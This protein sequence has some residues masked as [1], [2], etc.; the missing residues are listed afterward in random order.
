MDKPQRRTPSAFAVAFVL[1]APILALGLGAPPASAAT[2]VL[3][4]FQGGERTVNVTFGYA[5]WNDTLAIGIPY[6]SHV[7]SA[8]VTVSGLQGPSIVHGVMDFSGGAVGSDRW[9]MSEGGSAIYPPKAD[10]YGAAWTAIESWDVTNISKEDG[11]YWHT[12]TPDLTGPPPWERSI[13]VYQFRPS[14]A[15]STTFE[16]TWNG[17]G[18][19]NNNESFRYQ[20][21]LW[22]YDHEDLGWA[23]KAS[24]SSNTMGDVW[25][26]ASLEAGGRYQ[27]TNGSI[28]VAVVSPYSNV[29][30]KPPR[31][32]YDHG[33]L[34]TDYIALEVGEAGPLE[35]PSMVNLTVGAMTARLSAGEMTGSVVVGDADGLA[36]AIQAIIDAAPVKGGNLSV[37]FNL[38]VARATL[39]GVEVASLRIEHDPP[40][41]QPPAYTGPDLFEVAEDSGW[42]D[43]LTFD[44]HFTDD[45]NQ[46]QLVYSVVSVSD[47][48]SLAAMVSPQPN[49]TRTLSVRPDADF[50]GDVE[51]VIGA[52]DLFDVVGISGPLTVR[53]TQVPDAPRIEP[54]LDLTATEG[55]PFDYT[56]DCSDADLPAD[57]LTFSDDT[58]LF[59]IDPGT[60]RIN[61]TPAADQ[62]GPHS[63]VVTLTDSFG[64]SD[65]LTVRITVLNVNDGPRIT[66]PLSI[67]ATQGV[68]VVY[69]IEVADP[70]L[71][72][73][74]ALVYGAYSATV[75]VTVDQAMGT[76]TFTP[77]NDNVPSIDIILTVRDRD[78][79]TDQRTLRVRVANV[80]DPPTLVDPGTQRVDQGETVSVRLVLGDV[81][82]SLPLPVPERLT[83][84]GDGPA[85][86]MPDAAGWVNITADQ[87]M[88]GEHLVS[89][90]VTDRE[91]LSTTVSVL[92]VI[93]DLNDMPD[94]T[95]EVEGTYTVDE[96]VPFTLLLG[97][98]DLDG[99]AL[100][101]TDDAS[102]FN[103]DPATGNITFTP[104]QGHVGTHHVTVTVS[105]GKGGS[106]AV[107]FDMVVA[108]VND[109]PVIKTV[110]PQNGSVFKEGFEVQFRADASDEDG[111]QLTCTWKRGTK[112]LGTGATLATR[113]LRPGRVTITLEV[114]DGNATA[115]R[116][117]SVVVEAGEDGGASKVAV[118]AI[119]IA[120]AIV[121][122]VVAILALRM[123]RRAP[124]PQPPAAEAPPAE[125][126]VAGPI[127]IEY[128]E[129]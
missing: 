38:S 91:G 114:T 101:W 54:P 70:D 31:P 85:W 8:S 64:L 99:D 103:I 24:Y 49:G 82:L 29:V 104:R 79:M 88:V 17:Y 72:F 98:T 32:T 58:D 74:D 118:G 65:G 61:W 59:D 126:Q 2:V 48:A 76:V 36:S 129:T 115:T 14:A 100:T 23:N 51:V 53:V 39:S 69:A 63:V 95:T 124:P 18:E 107:S 9:A 11:V 40:V 128:R 16:L 6:G 66:S 120:V 47:P 119:V 1:I 109:A 116:T 93:A 5:P 26:N 27:A 77:G 20:A 56:F 108:N 102:L 44:T 21:E 22:L 46:G 68:A 10:P 84:T 55:V 57:V 92:W 60:G 81:D 90:T 110:L 89:Y 19:C 105:D 37:P 7:R 83:L 71:P 111:D 87:S 96:D 125:A 127:E 15:G 33:H 42:S 34:Y 86:S 4:H 41:N 123:T 75:A 62:V 94:I 112:V 35:Y 30:N 13:Q 80:N 97:A 45:H 28:A 121:V 52:R 73:G 25:L 106:R 67:D 78:G 12:L 117:L 50:Q 3:D 113:D 122:A 43:V